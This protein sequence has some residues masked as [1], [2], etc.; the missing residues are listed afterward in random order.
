MKI[1][2]WSDIRCPFCYIGKRK[3]ENALKQFDDNKRVEVNWHS[4]ELDPSLQTQPNID[5]IDH[6]TKTKNISREQAMQMF[7]GAK[8]MAKEVELEMNLEKTVVANSFL[9][10][11]LLH[12]AKTKGKGDE[13]KEALLKAHFT[14]SKNIDDKDTLL[15]IAVS[16]GLSLQETEQ[17]LVSGKFSQAVREDEAAAQRIGISGVPFFIFNEKY[18]VSGAQSEE[19]F[20]QVLNKVR[21]EELESIAVDNNNSCSTN[22][23]D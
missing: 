21:D 5:T 7:N 23:C 13:L 22:S 4:F 1:D 6:F 11:Q 8:K 18:A 16:K 3:L 17:V 10:H 20:L 12:F 2:I 9:A 19:S 14:E 15:N